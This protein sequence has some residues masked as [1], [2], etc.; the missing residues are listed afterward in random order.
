MTPLPAPAS[1]SL[2][3]LHTTPQSL[4]RYTREVS[5]PVMQAT[6]NQQLVL[7]RPDLAWINPDLAPS[8]SSDLRERGTSP[9]QRLTLESSGSVTA[10][11]VSPPLCPSVPHGVLT[12]TE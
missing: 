7:S 3:T 10:C 8:G 4:S 1:L 5:R 11:R 6:C 9:W 2:R 12:D